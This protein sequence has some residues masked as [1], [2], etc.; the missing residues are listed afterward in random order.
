MSGQQ[1]VATVCDGHYDGANT[2]TSGALQE[3]SSEPNSKRKHL[4]AGKRSGS[5]GDMNTG[6]LLALTTVGS[7]VHPGT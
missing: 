3:A 2:S 1:Q 7:S 4:I 6:V 5:L